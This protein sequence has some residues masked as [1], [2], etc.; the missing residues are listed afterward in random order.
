MK[1]SLK[2]CAEDVREVLAEV[3][4]K[5]ILFDGLD[6][7]LIGIGNR[8]PGEPLAIY[9]EARIIAIFA[10]EMTVEEAEEYYEHNVACLYAGSHTPI[11]I[12]HPVYDT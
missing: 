7:A 5:A 3:N 4:P 6:E 12:G 1:S 2:Y 10:L 9:D 11:I 8:Y